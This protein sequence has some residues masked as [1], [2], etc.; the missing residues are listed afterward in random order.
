MKYF[1]NSLEEIIHSQTFVM[2]M[3]G[4]VAAIPILGVKINI[5]TYK[6]ILHVAT[7]A[8]KFFVMEVC[9]KRKKNNI[10]FL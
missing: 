4:I 7:K 5:A 9:N 2:K 6:K 10:C 1:E 8:D 3:L